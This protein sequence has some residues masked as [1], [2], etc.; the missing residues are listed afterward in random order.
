MPQADSALSDSGARLARL[1]WSIASLVILVVVWQAIAALA[2][3]RLL[4]GPGEV[5]E[6][7][8]REL[9]TG[10][11]AWHVAATCA[12]VLASFILAMS[13]GA[14]IGTRW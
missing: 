14:A 13:V 3:S 1:G 11:L 4:P 12:R 7:L 8:L 5:A 10:G 6:A 2:A 9:R